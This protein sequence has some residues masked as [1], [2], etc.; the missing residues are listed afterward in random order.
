MQDVP[1]GRERNS[2]MTRNI[3]GSIAAGVIVSFSAVAMAEHS[4]ATIP[5]PGGFIQAG[6]YEASG[7]GV[8]PGQD[9]AVSMGVG[10]DFAE[11]A[12]SGLSS[13]TASAGFS[14]PPISCAVD[15]HVEMGRAR[16]AASNTHMAS[17]QFVAAVANGGWKETLTIN[18]AGHSGQP[19]YLVFQIR[20]RGTIDC[21]GA[22]GLA[23]LTTTGY[24]NNFELGLNAYFDPGDS[25]P[26]G[27]DRQRAVWG[28]GTFGESITRSVDSV[29]TMSAPI[30]IGQSFTL[31]VYAVA[32]AGQRSSGASNAVS[33]SSLDFSGPGVTWNGIVAVYAGGAPVTGY[34]I[35]SATST[36]WTVPIDIC[37]G[38]RGDAN[39]DRSVDFF[40]I[41][42]FLQALFDLP[43]YQAAYC[44]GSVCAA[45]ASCDGAVDFFDI[46]PFLACLFGGCAACP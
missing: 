37:P 6:A 22:T 31:G 34:T 13:A 7:G 9:M 25:D 32:H 2:S 26:A 23:Y 43:A 19:A 30:T 42:P 41:D 28:V 8:L 38:V 17:S 12:F 29:V 10:Q 21:A 40:D 14:N 4:Q 3:R 20:T 18:H 39:C 46:D 5:S 1:L 44:G 16:I 15:G 35:S 45:D 24:V 11:Q 33:T 27:S 36:D